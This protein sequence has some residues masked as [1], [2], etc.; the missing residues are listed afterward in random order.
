M[1][2]SAVHREEVV[3]PREELVILHDGV[4]IGMHKVIIA[5]VPGTPMEEAGYGDASKK[6]GK[7]AESESKT[8]T[9]SRTPEAAALDAK[10]GKFDT[11]PLSKEVKPGKQVIDLT[12]TE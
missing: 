12:L 6:K 10:Y 2:V 3:F 9:A 8:K 4:E 11:T 5:Y 1:A 7:A